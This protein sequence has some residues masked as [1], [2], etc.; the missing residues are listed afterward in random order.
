MRE[1][2]SNFSQLLSCLGVTYDSTAPIPLKN[3]DFVG[4]RF[5]RTGPNRLSAALRM[6][7]WAR[8]AH[9]STARYNEPHDTMT[10]KILIAVALPTTALFFQWIL[11]PWLSPFVWFLF[12]PASFLAARTTGLVGG[13][14]AAT[15]STVCVWVFFLPP[16]VATGQASAATLP[17]TAIFLLTSLLFSRDAQ[18]RL[19][20]IGEADAALRE[21]QRVARL[22][23]WSRDLRNGTGLWSDQ[24]YVL[25]D[26]PRELGPL[27]LP[28]FHRRFTA[29]SEARLTEAIGHCAR[30]GVAFEFDA[31][32]ARSDG[33]RRRWLTCRGEAVRDVRGMIVKLH[34]TLQD[35]TVRKQMELA[36]VRNEAL[37]RLF[38]EHAPAALAMFDHDMRYIAASRRWIDDFRLG[39][40]IIGRPHYEIFQNTP[41]NWRDAHRRGLAGE[42]VREPEDCYAHPDGTAR[43][44]RW[45]V[46][47]W[48]DV[49]DAIGGIVIFTEDITHFRTS[50]EKIRR[51]AATLEQRV[52][53]RTAQLATANEEL[54]SF[55]YAVS[56]D[57]R[58]P[59]RAMSGFSQALVED[60]G[61]RLP[62]E[63]TA[64]L[65]EIDLASRHM[66]D[67]ID[68]LL[69]LSRSTRGDARHDAVDMTRL[70]QR[71]LEE[72]A[73]EEPHRHV[74]I[75]VE[76]GLEAEGDAR[77][78]D[79][80]LRNLLGN[81]WKYTAGKDDAHISV[82][83]V[84]ENGARW[85]RIADNGAGFDMAYAA[86]LFQPF[87]RLHRQDE[88]PGLGVGLA[89]V[90]RIVRRHGGIIEAMSAPGRGATFRFTLSPP[91]A[92]ETD[93]MAPR[94]I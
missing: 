62:Q 27:S 18:K 12:F 32:Y 64:Y 16:V 88:F 68:S 59:L 36:L 9:D 78:I 41:E 74:T 79:T 83:S 56:H 31:E 87:Q 4:A 3:T 57:L 49:D 30:E 72:L 93:A 13:L 15:I 46:R 33:D 23:V 77:M 35:V 67:L 10:R 42:V 37:M 21:A 14:T 7:L 19:D 89:T 53:E 69:A 73:R 29:A 61:E 17:S 1:L 58:A 54:E 60:H 43:W 40:D 28:D 6:G 47:P 94:T 85:F 39:A 55:C 65:Y 26:H 86:R 11:W 92:G 70:A 66:G 25:L 76:Q 24:M 71:L 48:R 63:A 38:I 84:V 82:S 52:A 81:A 51:L 20:L 44:L 5:V 22:G 34:G 91:L 80:A 50:R 2:L 8:Q 45:E 90:Q 75:D